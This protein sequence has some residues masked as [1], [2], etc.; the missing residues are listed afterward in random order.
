L[1]S[2]VGLPRLRRG[3][4]ALPLVVGW[5]RVY[6]GKHYPTDILGGWLLGLLV[7]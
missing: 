6:L 1:R 4:W 5:S 3:I 7:G 2:A